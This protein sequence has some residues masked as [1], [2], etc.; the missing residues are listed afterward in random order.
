MA[1][2]RKR[3]AVNAVHTSGPL[4]EQTNQRGAFP[5]VV[6]NQ[7]N[8]NRN[9]PLDGIEYLLSVRNESKQLSPIKCITRE[10]TNTELKYTVSETKEQERLPEKT[11][12]QKRFLEQITVVRDKLQSYQLTEHSDSENCPKSIAEWKLKLLET[13]LSWSLLANMNMPTCFQILDSFPNWLQ[14]EKLELQAQWFFACLCK[15]PDLITGEETSILRSLFRALQ[16]T[17][18]SH[19]LVRYMSSMLQTV[20]V[21]CYQQVDLGSQ[22]VP[23]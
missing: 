7:Q 10:Q 21:F 11:E 16:T 15:L 20:L 23:K 12:W 8:T 4:D 22:L 9:V 13:P 6:V 1:P 14:V 18:T 5:D 3:N 2:K 17:H 19:S